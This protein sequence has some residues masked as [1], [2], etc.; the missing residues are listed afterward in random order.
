M[1]FPTSWKDPNSNPY[2]LG[3]GVKYY[4]LEVED[5]TQPS[6]NKRRVS[7]RKVSSDKE[8]R[9]TA[10][11]SS[12][13]T[14][15]P[16]PPETEVEESF[17][18]THPP[19]S[20]LFPVRT[21]ANSSPTARPSSLSRL[22]AQATPESHLDPV[23]QSPIRTPSPTTS[24]PLPSPSH[25]TGSIPQHIPNTASPLRPGS[26]ASRLSTTSRF[27]SRLPALGAAGASSSKAAPTI[28]L[29]EQPVLSASPASGS[30]DGNPFGLTATPSPDG[31]ISE[32]TANTVLSRRRTTSY[33]IPKASPLA[34][35]SSSAQ[36]RV[37]QAA[38]TSL[39]A[40]NTLA[41]L[42][43]SWGVAFSRK[44]KAAEPHASPS[45]SAVEALSEIRATPEE[46][47]TTPE[48]QRVHHY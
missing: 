41:N 46:D 17:L 15:P 35:S 34:A 43:S 1:D 3:E 11:S 23:P 45:G 6:H 16:G 12:P 19:N 31:S 42:A 10:V 22:L 20:A 30:L 8:A 38:R 37:S 9:D 40:T 27:S 21:R 4:M 28:A 14:L 2:G 26:R 25:H 5:W 44:R 36:G 29:T 32:V 48:A 7:S 13:P 39:T 24:P 47:R 18:V 33:Q